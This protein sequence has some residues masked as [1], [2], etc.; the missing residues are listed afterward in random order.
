MPK[1]LSALSGGLARA[2]KALF[3][4]SPLISCIL[5]LPCSSQSGGS[6]LLAPSKI[7]HMTE[8]VIW[9]DKQKI[10]TTGLHKIGV[11]FLSHRGQSGASWSVLWK[12]QAPSSCSMHASTCFAAPWPRHGPR[13]CQTSN[14]ASGQ[15]KEEELK[16]TKRAL[17]VE[18]APRKQPSSRSHTSPVTSHW[19]EFTC[20]IAPS[21]KET[22][23]CS[24]YLDGNT[25]R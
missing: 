15:K 11:G 7:L 22:G 13:S 20:M 6:T 9:M 12:T 17:P 2:Y 16:K 5:E 21:Y 23:K 19:P 14:H 10:Q 4:S 1:P 24:F 8:K 25:P 18:P 3:L